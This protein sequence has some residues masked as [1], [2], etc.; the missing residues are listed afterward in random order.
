MK[1]FKSASDSFARSQALNSTFS[2]FPKFLVEFIALGGIVLVLILF[3]Q[4]GSDLFT[5]L[6]PIIVV[7]SQIL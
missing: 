4:P 2:I 6:I 5:E 1:K 3:I 7:L